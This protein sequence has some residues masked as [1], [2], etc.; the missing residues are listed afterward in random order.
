MAQSKKIN[1]Y[2]V[3]DSSGETVLHICGAVLTK[4]KNVNINKFM[5]PMVRAKEQVDN[6]CKILE[7]MPG[8]VYYTLANSE[9]ESYLLEKCAAL[10]ISVISVINN[11]VEQTSKLLNLE[12]DEDSTGAKYKVLDKEYNKRIEAMNFTLAH[13]DGQMLSN[14]HEA[15]IA[16]IGVSRTSKSPT[17][18]YLAQRGFKVANIPFVKGIGISLDVNFLKETLLVG[19]TISPERLRVI[20]TNRLNS[21]ASDHEAINSYTDIAL[22]KEEVVE[23]CKLFKSLNIKVIDVT[24]K[25]IEE[26]A[27]EII[28]LYYEQFGYVQL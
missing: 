1:V 28:S 20:R 16:I 11:V 3:S 5:W 23:A 15:Q 7:K 25:A 18:L 10:N 26:T 4:F 9:I 21:L 22:I 2:L 6:L 12:I 17:S 24:G 19:L 14:I 8:I 13:D 27:S